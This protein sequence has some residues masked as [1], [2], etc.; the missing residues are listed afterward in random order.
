MKQSIRNSIAYV[1]QFLPWSTM[2]TRKNLPPVMPFYHLVNNTPNTYVNS[3]AV[4]S[5]TQFIQELEFLL[6]HFQ[7][8]TLHE[9]VEHPS[10][11]KMHLSFDDGLVECYT[12]IAPI[13]K[14]KGIPATFFV[15]PDFIDNRNIFHR[16]KQAILENE[17]ILP[18][19][20][21]KWFIQET[22]ELNKLAS[23]NNIDFSTYHPYLTMNQLRALDKDGFL[24]GAHSMNHP[25]MWTLS[26]EQQ[27]L[28]VKESVN[29]VTQNFQPEIRAFSFPFTDDR[30]SISLFKKMRQENIVDITMGTAGLKFDCVE[31]HFQ[32]IPI[33]RAHNWSIKKVMHY[34]YFYFKIRNLLEANTV[35]RN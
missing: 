32:R 13:L 4:R 14:E 7:P 18:A 16:F 21:R 1:A 15:N 11:E 10:P 28:Q 5:K 25:E 9:I 20:N 17:G 26:E 8:V 27:L 19:G 29:W 3:Y 23:D 30:L 6:K 31:N 34:E 2:E 22:E 12:V 35:K 33:E 24:I